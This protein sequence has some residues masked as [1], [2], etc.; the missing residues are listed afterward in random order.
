M[1]DAPPADPSLVQSLQPLMGQG[2]ARVTLQDIIERVEGHQGL[3]PVL[4]VLTLPVLLP[5]PPGLSMILALPL[6]LVAPQM[7]VGRQHLWLPHALAC[8]SVARDKLA[9]TFKRILPWLDRI[10]G[11]AKPR[12]TFL[13]GRVGSVLAGI[14]CTAMAVLLVLPIPF[15]NLFPALTICV[16]ALGVA[17][18]DGLFVLVGLLMLAIAVTAVVWGVHGARLGIDFLRSKL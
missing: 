1:T 12:L 6:L 11:V 13:T 17:R 16:M 4:F 9:K 8:Q 18:R 2:A 10:E 7:I 5:L 15:A 14:V 3:A